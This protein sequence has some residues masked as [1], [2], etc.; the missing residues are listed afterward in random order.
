MYLYICFLVSI[1]SGPD[2]KS[3]LCLIPC[4]GDNCLTPRDHFLWDVHICVPFP[5]IM[6]HGVGVGV[7]TVYV[8]VRSIHHFSLDV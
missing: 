4:W 2:S 1:M 3:F 8:A 6:F 7:V 5:L